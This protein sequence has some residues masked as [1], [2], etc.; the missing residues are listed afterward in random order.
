MLNNTCI[1]DGGEL[2]HYIHNATSEILCT[3]NHIQTKVPRRLRYA[4][5]NK[6]IDCLW[7]SVYALRRAA[8]LTSYQ[9]WHANDRAKRYVRKLLHTT[10]STPE[11]GE[12]PVISPRGTRRGAC[13]AIRYLY[14]LESSTRSKTS[15]IIFITNNY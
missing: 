9:H 11:K 14:Y 6:C 8:R 7:G 12:N 4:V 10:N 2:Q 1:I 13:G 3:N 5:E 15:I